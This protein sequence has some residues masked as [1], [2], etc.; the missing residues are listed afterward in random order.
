MTS[1][2]SKKW[3]CVN[4]TTL[5]QFNAKQ[6]INFW[7][8]SQEQQNVDGDVN[9]FNVNEKSFR[10]LVS[11]TGWI[12]VKFALLKYRIKGLYLNFININLF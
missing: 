6:I 5:I 3:K 4:L 10:I 8:L 1:N 2:F 12:R 11:W 9:E 7:D